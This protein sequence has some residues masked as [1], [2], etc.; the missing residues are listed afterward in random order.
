VEALDDYIPKG[1][2]DVDG[3]DLDSDVEG[4]NTAAAM[5]HGL[6]MGRD[7]A[8]VPMT[9]EEEGDEGHGVDEHEGASACDGSQN[10]GKRPP[11]TITLPVAKR[12][13]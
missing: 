13:V 11:I 8:D 6:S 12:T 7:S 10:S 4:E 3:D 5:F 1:T 2:G 9:D